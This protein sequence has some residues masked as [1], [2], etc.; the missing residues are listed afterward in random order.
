MVAEGLGT[1]EGTTG[2]TSARCDGFTTE[3]QAFAVHAKTQHTTP[4]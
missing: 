4:S 1:G 3:I 2:L